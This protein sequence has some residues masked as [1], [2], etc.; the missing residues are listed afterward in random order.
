M[1]IVTYIWLVALTRFVVVMA[2]APTDVAT[3]EENGSGATCEFTHSSSHDIAADICH[4]FLVC[5]LP[6]LQQLHWLVDV[7]QEHLSS[8]CFGSLKTS[9]I[10]M[11]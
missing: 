1:H 10:S 2:E 7:A 8:L 11:D 6:S 4:S 9:N 5:P 3:N